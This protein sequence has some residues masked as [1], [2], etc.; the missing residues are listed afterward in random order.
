MVY[1]QTEKS[2]SAECDT[3]IYNVKP[4]TKLTIVTNIQIQH[5]MVFISNR[6]QHSSSKDFKT[7]L[8]VDTNYSLD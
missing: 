8:Q 5:T 3:S 6:M 4:F 1:L 2:I 7:N